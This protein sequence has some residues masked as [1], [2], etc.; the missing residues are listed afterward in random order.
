MRTGKAQTHSTIRTATP[1]S[2]TTPTKKLTQTVIEEEEWIGHMKRSTDEAMKM[3]ESAKIRC[4]N[5]THKRMKWRLAQRIANLPSERWLVK[6]AEWN[7]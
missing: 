3:M 2:K 5:K 6:V 4:W 7:L 1:L